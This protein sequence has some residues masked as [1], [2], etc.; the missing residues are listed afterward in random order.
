MKNYL[1]DLEKELKK[2]KISDKEIKEIVNDHLEMLEEAAENGYRAF[3]VK[4][5]FAPTVMTATILEKHLSKKGTKVFG[6]IVLNNSV[7]G[8]NVKALDVAYA[9]GAKIVWMPTVS[10]L[11]HIKAHEGHGVKFPSSKGMTVPEEPIVYVDEEGNLIPEAVK[12]LEYVAKKDDL[13]LGTGHGSLAEVDATIC[14]AANLGIKKILVNHPFYMI[15]A[16]INIIKKWAELGAYIE[17]NAT[18][19][20]KDSNYCATQISVADDIIKNVSIDQII[21]DSDYGQY[22]NGRVSDGLVKFINLIKENCNVDDSDIEKMTK[23]N[24]AKLL[25]I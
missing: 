13:I 5:H 20:V 25:G 8:L 23:I 21:I 6:G 16:D 11:N 2:L 7:G 14:M 24:P 22:G 9:M 3:V 12:V 4:D 15:G 10:T 18:V 19:F 17:L 1:N